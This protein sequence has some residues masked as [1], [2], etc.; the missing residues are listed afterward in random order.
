MFSQGWRRCALTI[1]LP[2]LVL[3]HDGIDEQIHR[4]TGLIRQSPQNADL[5]FRRAELERAAHQWKPAI[6]D[7]DS[8]LRL[9]PGYRAALLGGG[10]ARLSAGDLT[11]ARR[12]FDRFLELVPG[13]PD[14]CGGGMHFRF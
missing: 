14:G 12:T 8:A 7:Y 4:V 6:T 1:L 3:G 5:Y 9:R 13:H 10:L 2:W 11:A